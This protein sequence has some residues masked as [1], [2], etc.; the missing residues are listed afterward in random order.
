M[1]KCLLFL[2]PAVCLFLNV[3]AQRKVLL[4][5]FTG[6][7]CA[8]CPIGTHYVDSM[9]AKYPNLIAVSLHSY[10]LPDSMF[11]PVIDTIGSTYAGGAPLGAIDRLYHGSSVAVYV[12][13]WDSY[14]QQRL[15]AAPKLNIT[16]SSNWD[17]ASRDIASTVSVSILSNLDSGDYRVGLYVVED[18]VQHSGAGYDQSNIYNTTVGSPFYG[19]GDPIV[20]F[21]H[22]RV[23]RALL[24]EAWGFTGMLPAAPAAAQNFAHIFHYI[25][26]ANYNEHKASLVAFVSAYSA[27]HQQDS[28]LNAA[29]QKLV[30]PVVTGLQ[31]YSSKS[32]SIYPNPSKDRMV[33]EATE[34]KPFSLQ[35]YNTMGQVVLSKNCMGNVT[36]TEQEVK[37]S[38]IYYAKISG[39]GLGSF[40]TTVVFQ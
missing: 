7:E 39:D 40:A 32:F 36:I 21:V 24:S 1:K 19:M 25:L 18:S 22:R 17:S 38:G 37:A 11:F 6:A 2:F 33:F 15:A 23:V 20:G 9:T 4:E 13:Q 5:D 35:L 29:Q 28:V 14:I 30:V 34:H 10:S 27:N 8:N 16:L 12:T 26:P 3:T 31:G